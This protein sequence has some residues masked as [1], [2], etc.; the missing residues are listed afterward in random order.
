MD[1]LYVCLFSNGHIKVGRSNEPEIRIRQHADRVACMGVSLVE[2]DRYACEDQVVGREAWLIEQCAAAA[3]ERFQ[4][5][6]FS[7]LNFSFIC[8]LA[9][10][11]AR[12]DL[13][14]DLRG[15][16][17]SFG[18]RLKGA[19]LAA[20]LTQAALG[21]CDGVG[22]LKASISSW[23]SGRYEPN[24]SQLRAIC[25][26]LNVSADELL[27]LSQASAARKPKNESEKI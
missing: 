12:M 15:V 19:R 14:Q 7:G 13:P 18:M 4:N 11:A 20:G 1:S 6:W 22:A 5:E 9:A 23:E 27:G 25:E 16:E 2:S 26:R 3:N 21:E 17:D 10:K 24:L 8:A